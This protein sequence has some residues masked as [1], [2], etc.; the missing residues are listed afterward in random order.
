MSSIEASRQGRVAKRT[1][2]IKTEGTL[3][4]ILLVLGGLLTVF[5]KGFLTGTNLSNL[6]RQT[7]INGVVALGMTL[8]IVSG[9][10]DLSVGSTVGLAGIVVAIL[11]KNGM[12]VG[13]A[14]LGALCIA[15]VVGL[16]NGVMIFDGRIPPFIATLG[17]MTIVR[18]AIMLVSHARMVAGLPKEFL[19]FAQGQVLGFPNIFLVW[20]HNK[21]F[22]G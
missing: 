19:N 18:G 17:M 5:T 22:A 12:D 8:V 13:L 1:F 11:M 20:L 21:F 16:F 9:G 10:I 3:I 6:V 2:K 4:I 7:S 15:V 14:V